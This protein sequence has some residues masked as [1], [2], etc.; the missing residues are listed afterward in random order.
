MSFHA[1]L[2]AL[3]DLP[4]T[5]HPYVRATGDGVR[6]SRKAAVSAVVATLPKGSRVMA[7]GLVRL[8]ADWKRDRRKAWM[9]ESDPAGGIHA[10][11]Y[12]AL[13][14]PSRS[15]SATADPLNLD[16]T[17]VD[18]G[19]GDVLGTIRAPSPELPPLPY[20]SPVKG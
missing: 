9:V 5:T 11:M 8:P 20:I 10:P 18:A 14:A 13:P 1:V 12:A 15:H 3:N 2:T 7:V 19:T 17:F 4:Q 16:V 6:V